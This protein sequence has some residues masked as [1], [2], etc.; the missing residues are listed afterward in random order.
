MDLF[1]VVLGALGAEG[2]YLL[3]GWLHSPSAGLFPGARSRSTLW[4][5]C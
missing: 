2:R 4:A 3:G 1:L 5:R